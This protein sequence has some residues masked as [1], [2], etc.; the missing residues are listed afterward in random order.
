MVAGPAGLGTA[1]VVWPADTGPHAWWVACDRLT[2][3]SQGTG[4]AEYSAG[5]TLRFLIPY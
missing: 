1:E 3:E 2:G 5:A 4:I